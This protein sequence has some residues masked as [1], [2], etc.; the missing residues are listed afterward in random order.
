METN[1]KEHLSDDFK[2]SNKKEK[3]YENNTNTKIA[4]KKSLFRKKLLQN[5]MKN[6]YSMAKNVFITRRRARLMKKS[7]KALQAV[8]P[9][10]QQSS[11]SIDCF[12]N[13]YKHQ[14][15]EPAYSEMKRRLKRDKGPS[16]PLRHEGAATRSC[17]VPTME[18]LDP[19]SPNV[20]SV[21]IVLLLTLYFYLKL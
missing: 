1:T 8:T 19:P 7:D 11:Q 20:C 9:C 15:T 21:L 2:K 16:C 10:R 17:K 13:H 18:P 3:F 14:A 12:P 4:K 5:V 6:V